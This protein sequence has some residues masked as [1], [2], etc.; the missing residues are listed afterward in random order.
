[1][2]NK[3]IPQAEEALRDYEKAYAA[4]RYSFLELTEAQQMLIDLKMEAITAAANY[5]RYLVEIDRLTAA[6]LTA[7][8]DL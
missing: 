2:R 3:I 1:M 4:G 7:G 5:H 8:A 6:D